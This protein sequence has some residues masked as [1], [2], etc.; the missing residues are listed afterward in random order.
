MI[1]H[2]VT[3]STFRYAVNAGDGTP[4]GTLEFTD[5]IDRELQYR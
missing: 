5:K 4:G 3:P 2:D 1:V